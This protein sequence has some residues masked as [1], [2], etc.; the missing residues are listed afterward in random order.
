MKRRTTPP[1]AAAPIAI[2]YV[3]FSTPEQR[4]GDSLRR[5]TEA[6]AQ[7][8][9]RNGVILDESLSCADLGRS[10]FHGRHRDEKAALGKFL[11]LI[12]EGRVPRG[13]YLVIENLDRLSRESERTAMRLWL[14]ILDAG[15]NI[16]QLHP[17]TVF[18]HERSDMADIMRAIIELSRGHSESLIKSARSEANWTQAVTLARQGQEM[19]PRR[20]D[21]RRTK[22]ITGR[23]PG[24][25][26]EGPGAME[27][28][29]DRA[30]IVRRIFDLARVGY[31][32]SAIVKKFRAEGV[33]AFGAREQTEQEGRTQA[34]AGERYGCGEWRTSYVRQIL[35][36]RRA[37]GE[38]Q[39][40]DADNRAKGDVIENYYPPVVTLEA[41]HAA[42]A[43]VMSR[44]NPAGRTG[45]KVANLFGGLLR[46]ARDGSTYYA[47]TRSDRWGFRRMLLNRSSIESDAR[48]YTFDYTTF[49]S[50]ILSRLREIDPGDVREAKPANEVTVLREELNW[51]RQ[52]KAA[53][54]LELLKGDI[55]A[56]ADTLR[57]I[58]ARE[59]ELAAQIDESGLE[60]VVPR[61]NSWRDAKDLSA[62]LAD[63][64]DL[65]DI[66]TRLRAALRRIV[67]AVWVLV[68]PRGRQRLC[69]VQIR[70]TGGERC[71]S[72]LMLHEP[73]WAG[74]NGR[75]ESQVRV[76]SLPSAAGLD[77]RERE[78]ADALERLLAEMDLKAMRQQ[79]PALTTI[80]G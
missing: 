40:R 25:V 12:K 50:A 47:A 70:F 10:G 41:F 33:P 51:L 65:E 71:R 45:D 52:R 29:A 72:Y 1:A 16:V 49:E 39:P 5:Q 44:K 35:C 74:R 19:K 31:G 80:M 3:R 26:K 58:E 28:I 18:R 67:E 77:L 78:D 53:L 68:V 48:A 56:I 15:V 30:T 57:L 76:T 11:D 17:E 14:D 55:A 24:W 21:G 43:A 69:A 38:L 54:A 8:C 23:L 27:L 62:M 46:N 4:K 32:A 59:T 42:R 61:S 60:A 75:K 36:D 9:E 20:K 7:W 73:A 22:A 37:V 2:S 64:E 63:A 79:V 6:T 66:R 13:S 34:A